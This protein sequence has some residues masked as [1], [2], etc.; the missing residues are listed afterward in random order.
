MGGVAMVLRPGAQK[1]NILLRILPPF[2]AGA[3]QP[4][5]HTKTTSRVVSGWLRL[6]SGAPNALPQTPKGA[7][8]NFRKAVVASEEL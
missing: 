3:W 2:C 8:L 6:V 5:A 1:R 7:W 4:R